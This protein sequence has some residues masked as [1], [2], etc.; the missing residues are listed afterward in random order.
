MFDIDIFLVLSGGV[1]YYIIWC[2][3]VC[4]SI[5]VFALDIYLMLSSVVLHYII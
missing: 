5:L 4:S 2:V 3:S 1:L